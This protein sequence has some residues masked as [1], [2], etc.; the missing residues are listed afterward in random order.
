[1]CFVAA[2]TIANNA[3]E[4]ELLPVR[5]VKMGG[6]GPVVVRKSNNA[7]RSRVVLACEMLSHVSNSSCTPNHFEFG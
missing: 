1:V 6:S 3:L 5:K 2:R 4:L 7:V